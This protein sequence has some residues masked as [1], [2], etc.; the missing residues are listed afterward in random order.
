M[1]EDVAVVFHQIKIAMKSSLR[2]AGFRANLLTGDRD[3]LKEFLKG[4]G[5]LCTFSLED[6]IEFC[7][8]RW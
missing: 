2:V 4:R 3:E 8:V 1:K 6:G 7:T 5:Y